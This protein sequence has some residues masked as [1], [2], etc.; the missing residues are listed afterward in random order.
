MPLLLTLKKIIS[1]HKRTIVPII[2]LSVIVIILGSFYSGEGGPQG[3]CKDS[4]DNDMYNKGSILYTDTK[5]SHVDEDYCNGD[6]QVYEMI[7]KR[8]SLFSKN[9]LPEKETFNCQKGCINGAF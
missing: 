6:Y 5:G 1:D 3:T 7:C 9:S 8:T 4:D 2:V